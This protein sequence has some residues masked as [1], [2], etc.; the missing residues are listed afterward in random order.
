MIRTLPTFDLQTEFDTHL[1]SGNAY[2]FLNYPQPFAPSTSTTLSLEVSSTHPLVSL[3]TMIGPSPDWFVGV[4]GLDMRDGN[5]WRDTI[6]VDLYVH[7]GGTRSND[8]GFL[9][10]ANGPLESPQK[11][12]S[13]FAHTPNVN[14]PLRSALTADPIGTFVFELQSIQGQPGDHD[15]DGDVDG[16]DFLAWQRNPTTGNLS[17]WQTHY[18]APAT[19]AASLVASHAVPEPTALGLSL[20]GL[21]L[22]GL[23]LFRAYPNTNNT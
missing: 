7:N 12:I 23:R 8:E 6:T 2:S 14:D 4:S 16:I 10:C 20:F 17:E 15:G 9:C 5:L 13:L 19:G 22:F 1:A 11:A 18:G 21:G 3:V